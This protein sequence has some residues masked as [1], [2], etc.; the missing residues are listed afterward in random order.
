MTNRRFSR[1]SLQ[2]RV[3]LI[4]FAAITLPTELVVHG[5]LARKYYDINAENLQLVALT[6]V[7]MGVQYLPADPGAAVREANAYAVGH[8][9]ARSEI[10]FTNLSSDDTVLTIRVERKIP[11]YF[12]VLVVGG[13]PSR[14]I[15]VTASARRRRQGVGRPLG[16]RILDILSMRAKPHEPP[17]SG[18]FSARGRE[19]KTLRPG[20]TY[21]YDQ[22]AART[23]SH[24]DKF[25]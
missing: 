3:V 24:S 17:A 14:D 16:T 23:S 20:E 6:A 5:V 13:L 15:S 2:C 9:I 22:A 12:A 8:G 25:I 11:K 18:V 19:V 7:K 10:V 21:A 4:V 1:L